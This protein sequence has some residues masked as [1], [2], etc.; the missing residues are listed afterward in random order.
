MCSDK[1]SQETG[2][3]QAVMPEIVNTEVKWLSTPT[4]RRLCQDE[5]CQ[6]TRCYKSPVRPKYRYDKKCQSGSPSKAVVNEYPEDT[7]LEVTSKKLSPRGSFKKSQ[8]Q[9]H[10][11]Y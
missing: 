11:R 1:K 3:M 5:K 2:H 6:S 8:V 10:R 4:I 9:V 7:S